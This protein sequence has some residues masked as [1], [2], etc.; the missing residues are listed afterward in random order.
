MRVPAPATNR[1]ALTCFG[2]MV[3]LPPQNDPVEGEAENLERLDAYLS[4]L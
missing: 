4:K 3:G 2:R 1:E